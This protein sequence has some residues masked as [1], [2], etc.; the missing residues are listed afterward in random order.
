M[1]AS[2]CHSSIS[3]QLRKTHKHDA[4]SRRYARNSTDSTAEPHTVTPCRGGSDQLLQE[5]ISPIPRTAVRNY[6]TIRPTYQ[7]TNQ[8]HYGNYSKTF[9]TRAT[10]TATNDRQAH[11]KSNHIQGTLILAMAWP[12][13]LLRRSSARLGAEPCRLPSQRGCTILG[14][15]HFHHATACDGARRHALLPGLPYRLTAAFDLVT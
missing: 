11:W 14:T 1:C 2:C 7:P 6:F 9:P 8:N 15:A 4:S 12:R 13:Q 10:P 3:Q 5:A